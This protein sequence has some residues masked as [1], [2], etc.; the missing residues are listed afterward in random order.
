[1]HHQYLQSSAQHT[2]NFS[3]MRSQRLPNY[4]VAVCVSTA[5][6]FVSL[7]NSYNFQPP[8][9]YFINTSLLL[10]MCFF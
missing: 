8:H 5:L 6:V 7:V 4:F 2:Q 9:T 3:F 1:M 10:K